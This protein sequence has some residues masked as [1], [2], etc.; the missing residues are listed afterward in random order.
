MKVQAISCC[1]PR[2]VF[3]GQDA[4]VQESPEKVNP[5]YE[6]PIDRKTEK[7]LSILKSVGVA[8]ALTAATGGIATCMINTASKHRYLKAGGIGLLVGAASLLL[9]LPS[10]IYDTKVH[11]FAREKEMEVFSRDKAVQ[12]DLLDKLDDQV[13]DEEVP[14]ENKI[15]NFLTMSM[16]QKGG[17][18]VVVKQGM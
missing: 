12:S 2:R 4:K 13:Q 5:K 16:A 1:K 11:S 17:S 15:N 18:N 14:L 8:A 9:T 10:K 3:K 6:N 7:N